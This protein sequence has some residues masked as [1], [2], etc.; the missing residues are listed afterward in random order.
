MRFFT[1][2]LMIVCASC[3]ARQQPKRSSVAPPTDDGWSPTGR[4]IDFQVNASSAVSIDTNGKL[5]LAKGMTPDEAGELFADYVSR[6]TGIKRTKHQ[7]GPGPWYTGGTSDVK[8]DRKP[9]TL[10]IDPVTGYPVGINPCTGK[11]WD[12]SGTEVCD[13]R[14]IGAT[15]FTGHLTDLQS[16]NATSSQTKTKPEKSANTK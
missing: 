2:G 10:S 12:T 14:L 15:G 7:D 3:G 8:Y 16:A 9:M 4:L 6:E 13:S 5:H 1:I 11:Y